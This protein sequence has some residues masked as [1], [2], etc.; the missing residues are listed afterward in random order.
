ME[1]R[2]PFTSLQRT[3]NELQ[4]NISALVSEWIVTI[5]LKKLP[6]YGSSRQ[7]THPLILPEILIQP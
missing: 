5:P 4:A 3:V 1:S 6:L 2:H 7:Y